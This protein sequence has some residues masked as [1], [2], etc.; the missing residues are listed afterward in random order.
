MNT[1]LRKKSHPNCANHLG[2]TL[3]ELMVTV[4]ILGIIASIAAP[5][6]SK[7]LANQRVK[8]TASTLENVLRDAK[9]QSNISKKPVTISYINDNQSNNMINVKIPYS[10][11]RVNA[12]S[13]TLDWTN[14]FF[15]S[16]V[17]LDSFP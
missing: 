10:G 1:Y 13:V 15:K 8:S 16:A 4:V 17:A 5:I 7:Q 6:I 12:S 11:L 3:V 14:I 2:F 9:A